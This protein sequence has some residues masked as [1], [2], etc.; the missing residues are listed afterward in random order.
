[1]VH[2]GDKWGRR[3]DFLRYYVPFTLKYGVS[4]VNWRHCMEAVRNPEMY[5]FFRIPEGSVVFDIGS[6]YGDY[7]ILWEKRFHAKVFA[8]ELLEENFHEMLKN[9]ALNRSNVKAFHT[10]VGDG[11]KI[12]FAR[13]GNMASAHINDG[14]DPIEVETKRIDDFV[15]ES[16]EMPD[17]VKIDVEGFELDVLKG[18]TETLERYSPYLIVET[19]SLALRREVEQFLGQYSYTLRNAGRTVRNAGWMDEITNLF[20]SR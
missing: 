3:Y 13:R 15:R 18:M 7:A 19:H 8:F 14:E 4:F 1:M 9:I 20:F 17:L 2:I 11:G 12:R 5:D 10:A 6:Q 16:G